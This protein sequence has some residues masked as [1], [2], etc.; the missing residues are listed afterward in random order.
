M[1]PFETKCKII[2]NIWYSDALPDWSAT[3]SISAPLCFAYSYGH[4]TLTDIGV[5]AI[6]NAWV[7]LCDWLDIDS[8]GEYA[9]YH[10]M[11]ELSQTGD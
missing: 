8:H 2:G 9:S 3:W 10:D 6:E 5:T 1:T 7:D 4:C 11:L